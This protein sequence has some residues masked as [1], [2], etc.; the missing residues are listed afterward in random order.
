[1]ASHVRQ[2]RSCSRRISVSFNSTLNCY[3]RRHESVILL[4]QPREGGETNGGE[5]HPAVNP[6]SIGTLWVRRREVHAR[7]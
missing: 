7:L 4:P 6:G 2:I 5:T 3:H 1:M